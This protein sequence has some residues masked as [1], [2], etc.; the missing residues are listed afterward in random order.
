ML[1]INQMRVGEC[2]RVTGYQKGDVGY[3]HKLMA[4]GLTRGREFTIKRIAPLG[5]PVEIE[6]LGTSLCLRKNECELLQLER[7]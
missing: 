1:N 2:A 4:M 6:Y 5:C 3:R 7:V